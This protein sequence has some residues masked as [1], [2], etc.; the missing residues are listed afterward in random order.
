VNVI[1]RISDRI[2]VMHFGGVIAGGTPAEIQ[3][4]PEVPRAYRG[5]MAAG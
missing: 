3:R 5:G 4:N 2:S 1:M